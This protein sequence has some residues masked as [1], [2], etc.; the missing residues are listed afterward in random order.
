MKIRNKQKISNK[1]EITDAKIQIFKYLFW[2]LEVIFWHVD[3]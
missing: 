2:V 1:T 3:A